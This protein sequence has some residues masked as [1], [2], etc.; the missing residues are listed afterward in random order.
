MP[1]FAANLTMMFNEYSFLDRFEQASKAGFEAVEYLFPYDYDPHELA[2]LLKKYNL[3]QVLFN[4]PA[5]NWSAGDRGLA[6]LSGREKEFEASID[7]MLEYAKILNCKNIHM[8]AGIKPETVSEQEA[9]EIYI[10][11]LSKVADACLSHEIEILLEPIN[12]RDMP[13]YFLHHQA[14]AVE[15]IKQVNATN[16]SLQMDIYHCQITE[17]DLATNIKQNFDYIGHIQVASVQG[18]H[19]PDAGEINYPYLFNLLDKSDYKGWIGC[20]YIPSA[21]THSGLKWLSPYL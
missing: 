16:V 5:G 4:M 18:R 21:N 11:N 19:E 3:Q 8:M 20:E 2:K 7:K 15:I 10:N 12:Q 14:Q 6:C 9:K 13:H 1:R 17:G